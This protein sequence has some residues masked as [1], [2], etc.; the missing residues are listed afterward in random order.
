[1]TQTKN[2]D[3]SFPIFIIKSKYDCLCPKCNKPMLV[4]EAIFFFPTLKD[5]RNRSINS[6]L[7]CGL[8]VIKEY[9]ILS[10]M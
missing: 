7:N 1:M 8:E 10:K 4:G 9:F 5:K 6:C 2:K 3:K